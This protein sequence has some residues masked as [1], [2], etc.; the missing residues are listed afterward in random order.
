MIGEKTTIIE[1]YTNGAALHE[2]VEQVERCPGVVLNHLIRI[3][4]VAKP[5]SFVG[6]RSL[7]PELVKR[8]NAHKLKFANMGGG[9]FSLAEWAVY[10]NLPLLDA[11]EA[12]TGSGVE[13]VRLRLQKDMKALGERQNKI[14]SERE[15]L[16]NSTKPQNY[17]AEI[18][19]SWRRMRIQEEE[20]AVIFSGKKTM[21]L[22]TIKITGKA[23]REHFARALDK[24]TGTLQ[25]LMKNASW[26]D[27]EIYHLQHND[28][29]E[30]ATMHFNVSVLVNINLE[31]LN[32]E[33]EKW[34]QKFC[35]LLEE[36]QY[37]SAIVIPS[38]S[39]SLE[40]LVEQ[41]LEQGEA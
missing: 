6:A 32:D 10:Y 35:F 36:F 39:F 28:W 16:L 3:G 24:L 37:N 23:C 26:D 15:A 41:K 34:G 4:C 14:N 21:A 17:S 30:N 33:I 18:S 38:A 1:M 2:I 27:R 7:I 13:S 22:V 20:D 5:I 29:D 31:A 40:G 9:G 11:F 12:A 25:G 19:A 8:L